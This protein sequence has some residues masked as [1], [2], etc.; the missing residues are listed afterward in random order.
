M[1][2]CTVEKCIKS[3]YEVGSEEWRNNL[4]EQGL[5]ECDISLIEEFIIKARNRDNIHDKN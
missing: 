2:I 3:N 5:C 1:F 4:L